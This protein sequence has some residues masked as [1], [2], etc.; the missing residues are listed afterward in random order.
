MDCVA[1]SLPKLQSA[2]FIVKI[3]GATSTAGKS[4]FR[5]HSWLATVN[6]T[7]KGSTQEYAT[8][9]AFQFSFINLHNNFSTKL[10]NHSRN[11]QKKI[12]SPVAS[13]KIQCF[14]V[15]TKRL[16]VRQ[17][18]SHWLT[19]LNEKTS[20]ELCFCL[21]HKKYWQRA[22]AKLSSVREVSPTVK[23]S[24]V[25]IEEKCHD[26]SEPTFYFVCHFATKQLLSQWLKLKKSGSK[27]TF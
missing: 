21:N 20:S 15:V 4:A 11:F 26:D 12:T 6:E 25:E 10:H 14:L 27:I 23:P 8:D 18:I 2:W 24:R 19:S 1:K 3:A 17:W 13:T 7:R 9:C 16:R 22:H 5:K